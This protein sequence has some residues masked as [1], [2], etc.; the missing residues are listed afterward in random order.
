MTL[1]PHLKED[2]AAKVALGHKQILLNVYRARSPRNW[3]RVRI[4]P[5]VYGRCVGC[6]GP[7]R[8]MV[9]VPI[10]DLAAALHKGPDHDR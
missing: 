2:V 7:N 3:D 5:G 8:Y 4:V 1:D 9:D 10:A 6:T